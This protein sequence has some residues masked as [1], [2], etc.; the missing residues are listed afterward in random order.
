[1]QGVP[2]NVVTFGPQRALAVWLVHRIFILFS[3]FIPSEHPGHLLRPDGQTLILPH[4]RTHHQQKQ[5]QR[6]MKASAFMPTTQRCSAPCVLQRPGRFLGP[7]RRAR[8]PSQPLRSAP[9]KPLFAIDA[10]ADL[11]ACA[12]CGAAGPAAGK[13]GD[14]PQL[15]TQSAQLLSHACAGDP[16]DVLVVPTIR[17]KLTARCAWPA[18]THVRRSAHA[19]FKPESAGTLTRT[20]AGLR[21]SPTATTLAVASVR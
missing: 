3:F 19:P 17:P 18:C 6:N 10:P 11:G 13:A 14:P 2:F 20:H 12:G 16:D 9:D 21:R 1:M 15:R 8:A 4:L 7:E 5:Q